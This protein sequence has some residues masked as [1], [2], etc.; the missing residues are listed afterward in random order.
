[1]KKYIRIIFH[2]LGLEISFYRPDSTREALFFKMLKEFDINTIFDI[3]ANEGQFGKFIRD[4]GYRGIIVS[5]EPLTKAYQKLQIKSSGDDLWN[6][7]P[8]MAIGEEDGEVKINIANNSESSSILSML[9]AHQEAAGNSTYIGSEV[10]RMSK[11][12]SIY[13]PYV[14]QDSKIFLKIDTQG[15]EDRVLRGASKLLEQV[16]GLQ[17]ELSLTPLYNDQ[18]LFDEMIGNLKKSGFELWSIMPVFS[19]LKTGRLLQVDATFFRKP[20]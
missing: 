20:N 12:D 6:I 9:K 5:F 14:R 18:I 2:F 15:Y 7:A 3:G 16:V 8:Q 13:T 17:V 11:L 4:L 19:D 10:V 1:M